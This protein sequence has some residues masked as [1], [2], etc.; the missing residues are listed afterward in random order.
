MFYVA[1][2]GGTMKIAVF[3]QPVGSNYGGVLQ[4]Y[5]LQTYLLS[6]GHDPILVNIIFKETMFSNILHNI[7]LFLKM[8]IKLL[9]FNKRQYLDKKKW[10]L[11]THNIKNFATKTIRLT[12][13]IS[14]KKAKIIC[15]KYNFDAYIV[16]SD[17]VWRPKYS[18]NIATYYLNFVKSD[19]KTIKI[20]YA[21]SF[22]VDCWEYNS[23]QSYVCKKHAKK[24]DFVSVRE[25]SAVSIC[26]K[27]LDIDAE[28]VLDPTMLINPEH[29][30]SFFKC[31]N[32]IK[33]NCLFIYVLDYNQDLEKTISIIQS[34]LNLDIDYF[35]P[36]NTRC[37]KN[38]KVDNMHV[39][40]PVEEFLHGIKNS[41]FVITDSFHGTVFSIL[42]NKKFIT[43]ANSERGK[44]RFTSLLDQF[45]LQERIVL[46][47]L[48]IDKKILS[49]KINYSTVNELI[50][51]KKNISIQ[52]LK[53]ALYK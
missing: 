36:K 35:I 29:Y 13:E 42:F 45:G 2:L 17:Q 22:G 32:N 7:K 33:K 9:T 23:Y 6:L 8:T 27:K 5:A 21:A 25:A 46:S 51:V 4:A 10:H 37:N 48:N 24:F 20:A 50:E 11:D 53:K 12:D 18:P 28:H 49:K 31:K 15:K 19:N 43:Y 1:N 47:S 3:T 34:E 38:N 44:S 30:L 40:K 41:D 39:L 26:K 16:G 14:W 52:F